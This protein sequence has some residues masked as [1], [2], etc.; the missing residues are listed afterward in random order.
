MR[1]TL[2]SA[3]C[4]HW[5]LTSGVCLAAEP[6]PASPDAN[7]VLA[8]DNK[9]P[10]G[11]LDEGVLTIKLVASQREWQPE[12][13]GGRTLSVQVFGEQSRTP[14]VPGPL[15]RVPAGSEVRASIRNDIPGTTLSVFGLGERPAAS[16][17]TPL[18]VP[19]GETR[20]VRFAAPPPG[21][22]HYWAT[23]A[24][25]SLRE[26]FDVEGPLGGAFIVDPPGAPITDRV[27]VIGVWRKPGTGPGT[28]RSPLS[29]APS[30]G[31]RGP[32]QRRSSIASAT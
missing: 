27:F 6:S 32:R 4:A 9:R 25:R 26:R 24:N 11:S 15:I 20:E 16:A 21:T 7:A 3:C 8:N 28:G 23:T 18:R 19:A 22:Y 2:I 31:D 29:W 5:L 17:S 12:G 14:S 30:T 1:A 13:G 10:A